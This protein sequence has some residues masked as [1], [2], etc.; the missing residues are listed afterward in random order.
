MTI[1]TLDEAVEDVAETDVT[2]MIDS[3][4]AQLRS[5]GDG[6][7]SS[8]R[9]SSSADCGLAEANNEATIA[10]PTNRRGGSAVLGDET[11]T[12]HT[13]VHDDEVRRTTGKQDAMTRD[14]EEDEETASNDRSLIEETI[15]QRSAQLEQSH[16]HDSSKPDQPSPVH[17]RDTVSSRPLQLSPSKRNILE[18]SIQYHEQQDQQQ[19]DDQLGVR[20]RLSPAAV[21]V[22]GPGAA[23]NRRLSMISS[24]G[25]D[26]SFSSIG[27]SNEPLAAEIVPNDEYELRRVIEFQVREQIRHETTRAVEV[28]ALVHRDDS[29]SEASSQRPSSSAAAEP[30]SKQRR[31]V[32]I[33]CIVVLLLAGGACAV[34]I[35]LT[36][37]QREPPKPPLVEL[38]LDISYDK[39]IRYPIPTVNPTPAESALDW[40][41]KKVEIDEVYLSTTSKAERTSVIQK[42][43]LATMYFQSLLQSDQSA[44]QWALTTD[45]GSECTWWNYTGERVICAGDHIEVLDLHGIVGQG[46]IPADLALLTRLTHLSLSW[47]RFTGTIPTELFQ[48]TK[49][50]AGLELNDNL[51][52]GTIPT[53][54]GQLTIL[55]DLFLNQNEL[56]GP[57]PTELWRL[58]TLSILA[59]NVNRLVGNIPTMLGNLK[60]LKV[61]ELYNN[62]MSGP[63]PTEFGQVNQLT[64]LDI[65]NNRLSGPLPTELSLLSGITHFY[66]EGNVINGTVPEELAAWNDIEHFNLAKNEFTGTFP[67][68]FSNHFAYLTELILDENG[69]SGPLENVISNWTRLGHLSVHFNDFSGSIPSSIVQ[70]E[71]LTTFS[72]K[73]NKIQGT[74]PS[75]IAQLSALTKIYIPGN[76]L[77]GSLP[78]ELGRLTW[79][80][81]F[82]VY[83]NELTGSLPTDYG[84]WTDVLVFGVQHNKLTGTIPT[85]YE[86]WTDL[87]SG[88][89]EGKDNR[90]TGNM[91][92]CSLS[93]TN[94]TWKLQLD[95]LVVTCGEVACSCCTSCW[96]G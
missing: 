37:R 16:H 33:M 13:S 80:Q 54:I 41:S 18:R 68:M 90:F 42:F 88:Q 20:V 21:A 85:E 27:N 24:I 56:T 59:L 3:L 53:Q 43:V 22:P 72:A 44:P 87:W 70:L 48:L 47:N 10:T 25:D 36:R 28:V 91:T 95:T 11:A 75:E 86:S 1:G 78:S 79:M 81:H 15:L 74:I 55:H 7:R 50:K 60:Q 63:I 82:D 65:R 71:S 12:S 57:V 67:K 31:S 52:E 17:Q 69:F 32:F 14:E 46:S 84:S 76:Q 19:Q 62:K 83:D 6:S 40:L 58:T 29:V 39:S 38:I 5:T 4:P 26:S 64:Y 9:R 73:K 51:L 92:I 96:N 66:I 89:F 61:L 94:A 23:H 8:S 45:H 34:A 35:M 77:V 93:V 49:L 30:R 2:T